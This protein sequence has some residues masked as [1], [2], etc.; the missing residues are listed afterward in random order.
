MTVIT[1]LNADVDPCL[2][3]VTNLGTSDSIYQLFS[4]LFGCEMHFVGIGAMGRTY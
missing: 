2:G 4:P 1:E 3:L